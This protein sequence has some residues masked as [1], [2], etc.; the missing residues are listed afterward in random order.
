MNRWVRSDSVVGLRCTFIYFPFSFLFLFLFGSH[1]SNHVIPPEPCG[2]PSTPR[3]STLP[4]VPSP[5][6]H[7]RERSQTGTDGQQRNA[8]TVFPKNNT[9]F[10]S[11][12]LSLQSSHPVLHLDTHQQDNQQIT[13]IWSKTNCAIVYSLSTKR[14][15]MT[16][17]KSA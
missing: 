13:D 7:L 11:Q 17:D 8:S 10:E 12:I 5:S 15:H 16:F 4:G 3:V 14:E 1:P 6:S 2:Q 9:T